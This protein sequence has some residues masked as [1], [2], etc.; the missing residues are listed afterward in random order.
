MLMAFRAK[1]CRMAKRH[2]SR[3]SQNSYVSWAQ[4]ARFT[5]AHPLARPQR[6]TDLIA[7]ARDG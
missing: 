7:M 4:F 5:E 6:L 1:A 3:R 2:F